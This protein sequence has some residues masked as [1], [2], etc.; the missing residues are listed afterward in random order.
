M[1]ALQLHHYDGK[2]K[3]DLPV[4]EYIIDD[5]NN[6]L[7]EIVKKVP[8][9]KVNII[10]NLNTIVSDF[11]RFGRNINSPNYDPSNNYYAC[12][13]LLLSSYILK[14]DEELYPLFFE[15]IDDM[16][17]GMCPPGRTTRLLQFIISTL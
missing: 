7:F 6:A 13:L 5:L 17:T 11:S 12:E 15:Q 3:Y 9:N 4:V 1:E 10:H 2:L 14:R 8:I 16:S